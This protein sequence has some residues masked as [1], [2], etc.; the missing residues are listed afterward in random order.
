M[1]IKIKEPIKNNGQIATIADKSIYYSN[2]IFQP[3]QLSVSN[4]YYSPI[5]V[6]DN[7][8]VKSVGKTSV[9]SRLEEEFKTE[10]TAE[11]Y[12]TFAHYFS[13]IDTIFIPK[14][15]KRHIE[16]NVPKFL[17]RKIDENTDIAVELCLIILSNLSWTIFSD[18]KWKNLSSTIMDEQ[19][20][21]GKD[22]T[23]IYTS[24]LDVLKYS[25]NTTQGVIQVKT[26]S[27]GGETYQQGV[28]CKSYRL[29]NTF[30]EAGLTQYV[31]KDKELLKTREK[32]YRNLLIKVKDNIIVN[33]LFN[34]YPRIKL[35]NHEGMNAESKKLINSDYVTKKGNKL[36]FLNKHSRLQIPVIL[37][38]QFQFK[39]TT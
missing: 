39:V 14:K 20:R 10:N 36:V 17:L 34:L 1:T 6:T 9:K 11:F 7:R 15:A 22:N 4:S 19:T 23:R 12:D 8:I 5:Y 38:T 37:T 33:N 35:P 32:F 28:A 25:T 13:N 16:R 2:P 29:T 27:S 26:N 31:I 24:C 18:E 21:K 3:Y 30:I